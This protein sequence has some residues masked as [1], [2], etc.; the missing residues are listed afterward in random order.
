MSLKNAT[1][2]EKPARRVLVTEFIKEKADSL[3]EYVLQK[4]ISDPSTF[5]L[6]GNV[7]SCRFSESLKM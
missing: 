3:K 1:T 6:R 7:V 5:V 2:R 4:D